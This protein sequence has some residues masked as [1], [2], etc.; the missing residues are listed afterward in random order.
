M[1]NLN[2]S[3]IFLC[4]YFILLFTQWICDPMLR[5][6][7]GWFFIEIISVVVSINFF[8]IIFEMGKALRKDNRRRTWIKLWKVYFKDELQLR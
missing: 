6:R 7:I 5:Y 4:G 2:E 8:L 1:E 3:M